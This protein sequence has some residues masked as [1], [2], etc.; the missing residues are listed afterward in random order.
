MKTALPWI[1]AIIGG[2]LVFLG[3]AGFDQ[4]YLEWICL[5]P[6]LWAIRDQHPGRAFFIGWLAGI[7]MNIGGFY[8]AIQMFQQFAGMAWPLAALGLLLLAAANGIVFAAWAWATRLITH[9]TGWNVAWVSPVVWTALEK[10]WPEIF[11]NY[12]GASQYKLSLVTQIADLTGILGVTFIVVYINSTLFATLEQWSENRRIATRPLLVFAAV[13]ATVLIY[14]QVRI[15][16]VD[17]QAA[18]AEHLTIGLIQTNRGAGDKRQDP[19]SLLREHQEMS[20]TLAASQPLDLI[21]WPEGVLRIRL[22]SRE[23]SLPSGALGDTHIPTLFG[24]ILQSGEISAVPPHNT[25][26]LTD[27]TGR[28][29]GTYDKMVLVPFGEYIPFGETF[30]ALYSLVPSTGRFRAGE[31]REPLPLGK[32]LLSVNICYEDIFPGQVRSLMRG[33]HYRRIPDALFN[34]TNDSWYG[35]STEPIEHL[36]L[37]SF[38]SIEHRRSLVRSTN[39]GISAFVDPVGRIV[40]RSGVWT[41]ETLVDRVPM[42]QGRTLYALSG[43]WLGWVCALLALA[44]IGRA[45]LVSARRG[46]ATQPLV[47]TTAPQ[48]KKQS[49]PGKH[50]QREK[51]QR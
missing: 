37:A 16:A 29:L 2:I 8:W 28:I 39:T 27:G 35:K 43:D 30:P 38:R 3:Y 41:R 15:R 11:P 32:H 20:R 10:F 21:V 5:V 13:M 17:R 50:L 44:G 49:E 4:F 36:A 48:R 24:A 9:D 40:K 42:M 19:E 26:L 18:A 6:V 46:E 51:Q 14:G 12:L 34:L 7:V 23:G 22:L 47:E 45:L 31:S 1:A 33:G 25:A